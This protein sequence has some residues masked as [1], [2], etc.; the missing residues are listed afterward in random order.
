MFE[1]IHNWPLEHWHIELCS[2]CSLKCPR[3][4]RQEVPEGLVNKD[5][6]LEWF[7]NNFTGRLLTDVR[8]LT[9]C[10][11][12]GDPIYAK[13]FLKILSWFRE[14]NNNVQ[15]VVVTNGS[16]KTKKWWEQL[17]SILNEKD[18]IHFSLDGWDQESNNIYRVNCN[19]FSIMTGIDAMRRSKAHKTWA[20]IAFKFNEHRIFDMQEMAKKLAFDSFQLTLSSK[21]GKNYDTYP[22]DDPLQPSDKF[23]ASGRF[24]RT[25][26]GLSGKKWHD[27]CV[28]I[29]TKRFYNKDSTPSIIPLCMIGNKGLY[30]NAKGKF[31]PCCWTA[32]RYG[33]NKDIFEYIKPS[34]TLGEV[35]DDPMWKKLFGDIRNGTA[36][37]EC[38]EKC[39]AKKW[40]L[41]HA[42]QW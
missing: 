42:T 28:D 18:H 10:G 23:I 2:K 1:N 24:T 9:F 12:D 22:K 41:D 36:P 35:L 21:F 27:N 33:H 15:F 8:K 6:S 26:V 37:R 16:Y 32:L 19:W 40:S 7:K 20:A 5:L 39:S 13:D 4:S 34:Q 25:T 30:L 3:C 14:N 29:F 31:Y 38:G 17:D 11:D